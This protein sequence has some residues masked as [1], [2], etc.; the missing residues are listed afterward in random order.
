M[1]SRTARAKPD[2]F[3]LFDLITEIIRMDSRQ[4]DRWLIGG[5]HKGWRPGSRPGILPLDDGF[6]CHPIAP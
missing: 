1:A 5:P 4:D 3:E 2:G 6:P